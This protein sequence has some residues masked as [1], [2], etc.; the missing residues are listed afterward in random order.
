MNR[1]IE[2]L[3][4]FSK[5]AMEF[6]KPS[7]THELI[8]DSLS[9][10]AAEL[11]RAAVRVVTEYQ[12][13]CPKV[14]VNPDGI[15]QVLLNLFYNAIEAMTNGGTLTIK[16]EYRAS[17]RLVYMRIQDTGPGISP[18]E[19]TQL[20]HP[21]YTTKQKGTG[22]GLYI[23]RKILEEHNGSIRIEAASG[24]GAVF[25]I[26]LPGIEVAS[27]AQ[28]PVSRRLADE[29]LPSCEAFLEPA[30]ETPEEAQHIEA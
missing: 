1:F 24:G 13:P 23:S 16:T 25:I 8:K 30:S 14:N 18:D 20:F 5:P 12:N 9:I 11:Q 28:E 15:V 3:L 10:C 19:V 26:T 4:A 29:L 2:Q 6:A 7:D 22:L 21:F 27:Q 17:E